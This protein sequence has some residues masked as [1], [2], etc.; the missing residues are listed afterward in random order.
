MFVG[1]EQIIS[2]IDPNICHRKR[3]VVSITR[4]YLISGLVCLS[5]YIRALQQVV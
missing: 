2:P 4:D 3:C 5:D 1:F